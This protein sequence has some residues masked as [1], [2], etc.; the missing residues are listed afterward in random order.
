MAR[1]LTKGSIIKNVLTMSVPTMIGFSAQM[2]YDLVDI[3][4][5]GKISTNSFSNSLYS[6]Y[7]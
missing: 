2:I 6:G 4:W 7:G 3:Y 1:D 5:I